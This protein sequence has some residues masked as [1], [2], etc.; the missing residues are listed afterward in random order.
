MVVRHCRS[1]LLSTGSC[2]SEVKV[3][4]TMPAY[5]PLNFTMFFLTGYNCVNSVTGIFPY[6]FITIR[7]L[8]CVKTFEILIGKNSKKFIK[9]VWKG[10][11]STSLSQQSSSSDIKKLNRISYLWTRKRKKYFW[12]EPV[13]N[14]WFA[15]Q[16]LPALMRASNQTCI[17]IWYAQK[18]P[19][20]FINKLDE[21][22]LPCRTNPSEE[23]LAKF[24]QFLH[25]QRC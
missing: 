21:L 17:N 1:K 9:N 11:A 14:V 3:R 2:F 13:S 5:F 23:V 12:N 20:D 18:T 8:E 10:N 4:L 7:I 6:N 24:T 25:L 16:L 22:Y 19:N 15:F